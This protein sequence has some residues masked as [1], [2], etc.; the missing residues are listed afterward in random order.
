MPKYDVSYLCFEGS[1]LGI[2]ALFLKTRIDL[3]AFMS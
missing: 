2:F 1:E 3:S